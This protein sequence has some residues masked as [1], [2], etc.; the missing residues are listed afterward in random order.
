MK[1]ILV[2]GGAGYVGCVLV[3]KL[4]QAGYEVTV[5]DLYIYGEDVLAGARGNPRLRRGRLCSPLRR[6]RKILIRWKFICRRTH[7]MIYEG[8]KVW[9]HPSHSLQRARR[10][11]RGCNS[12]PWVGLLNSIR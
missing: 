11:R 7:S 12:C 1:K 10:A 9:M 2:T 5:L 3:P 6:T 4:L 8:L